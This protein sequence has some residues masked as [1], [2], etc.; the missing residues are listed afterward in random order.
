MNNFTFYNPTKIIFGKGE[1]KQLDS[2]VPKNSKV[3]VLYGGGSVKK[4]GTLDIVFEEL[5]KSQ[6]EIFEFGG[7]EPNPKFETLMKAVE[8]CRKE[9]IEFLLA[10]GGGSVMDGTKF[11]S[12]A[13]SAKEYVGREKEL[14]YTGHNGVILN[15]ILPIGTVVT[16]PATGSEMNSGGVI[17]LGKD[18]LAISNPL[19]FP[20]F[21]ILD[22]TLTYTLPVTQVANGIID[23]FV[24]TIEQYL[25]Y[26]INATFQDR[27]SEGILKSM[28]EI[29]RETIDNPTNYDLR[30]N[31][32]WNSTMALN[33]LI[34]AGV[35]QDWSIHILGHELTAVFGIDHAKTLAVVLPA[36]W[37]VRI[38][39]KEEKLAQYAKRVWHI[40]EG[41]TREKALKAIEKTEEFFQSLGISTKL[42]DYNVTEKQLEEVVEGLIRH[43][44][45]TLSETGDLTPKIAK[46]IYLKAL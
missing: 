2:L 7:I 9:K 43:K 17:T 3:L 1:L 27:T 14:V 39:K 11:I 46:E 23:T 40:T 44:F 13:V 19:T 33:G 6:R 32:V 35:P 5:K 10:V 42:S 30:A 38:E 18:K 12:I 4:F 21:S 29:G 28:I 16:L 37:K 31:L 8:I 26:P 22:P 25:T 15:S 36:L 24:H 45:I 41:T 20:V 34:G